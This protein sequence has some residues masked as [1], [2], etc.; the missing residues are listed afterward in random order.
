M[1]LVTAQ[2]QSIIMQHVGDCN[3]WRL[4]AEETAQ[5]IT[6]LGI[7]IDAR[8]VKRYKAKIRASAG[9]WISNLA[10]SKRNDCIRQYKERTEEL[11]HCQRELWQIVNNK[12]VHARTK[13][14]AIGKIMDCSSRLSDL[15]DRVPVVSAIRDYNAAE[16]V[17]TNK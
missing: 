12:N 7:Q 17:V 8:T 15:Y 5:Y 1:G 16:E 11:E 14:E 9:E 10:K 4:T 3:I 13:V 6:S 2:R